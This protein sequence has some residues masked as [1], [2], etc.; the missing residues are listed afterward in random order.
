MMA[1]ISLIFLSA[2]L[3]AGCPSHQDTSWKDI[4][5]WDESAP[6]HDDAAKDGTSSKLL[7]L[8]NK[9]RELRGRTGLAIDSYLEKYAQKHAEWMAN[10]HNLQHSDI[11][12]LMGRY[13]TAGENIAWNQEDELE[14]VNAWMKS[15]G[16]RDNIMNRQFSKV[17]FGVAQ[18]GDGSLFWCTVFGD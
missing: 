5:P 6:G 16:H 17:G 9:Q 11:S 4:K 15:P 10:K 7:S 2:M 12:V 1:K 3:A 18:A 14:V 8:H 13:H